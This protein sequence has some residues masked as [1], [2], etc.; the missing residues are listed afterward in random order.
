MAIA[1]A[2]RVADPGEEEERDDAGGVE[3]REVGAER[4]A[5]HGEAED[6]VEQHDAAERLGDRPEVAAVGAAE[7]GAHLPDHQREE[8][9]QPL[10]ADEAPSGGRQAEA[11]TGIS[12]TLAPEPGSFGPQ[13]IA[14]TMV[15][16]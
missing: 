1:L 8:H 13:A 2:H 5:A 7:L 15:R 9:P 3:Q 12:V 4:R 11:A 14:F 10:E 6:E 16:T